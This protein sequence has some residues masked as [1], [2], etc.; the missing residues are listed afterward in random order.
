[1]L[2]DQLESYDTVPHAIH[3]TSRL[4]DGLHAEIRSIILVQRPVDQD[5]P[6]T[7]ALLQ[8][9]TGAVHKRRNH[10]RYEGGHYK[11]DKLMSGAD[12]HRQGAPAQLVDDKFA[13]LKASR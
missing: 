6:Y 8:E 2:V 1:M 11:Q 7:L 3:Y 5:T 9:E 4:I 10:R 13:N 12:D